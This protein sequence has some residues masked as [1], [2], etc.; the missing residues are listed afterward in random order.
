MTTPLSPILER[1]IAEQGSLSLH[2]F[3]QIALT[4]PEHG[5]YKNRTA[6]GGEGDFIT[7]PEISQ[8]FGELCGLWGFDQMINQ[9]INQH[10]GWVEL[11]PGRGTLMADIIRVASMAGPE[12][13]RKWPV[14]LVEIH[15]EF[16]VEQRAKLNAHTDLHHHQDLSSLPPIPLIFIAN[17][18]F[19][20]LPIR[21]FVS[22]NANWYERNVITD[23]NGLMLSTSS[24][25]ETQLAL[26]TPNEDGIIAEYA[27]DLHPLV[28]QMATHIN[29]YGGAALIIDYGKSNA[30]GDSLQAVNNHQPVDIFHDP[31]QTDLSAWVNFK[32]IRDAAL[33]Q[34][35]KVFGPRSQGDFLRQLGLYQRAE[36]LAL[37]ASK[38]ERRNIAAAVDRLSAPAQ[39][40]NVFK[41]MALLPAAHPITSPEQLAG[42]APPTKMA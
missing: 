2:E 39:M 36:Q 28:G 8:M 11:G 22:K 23:G 5:Y 14:H 16:V 13:N 25:P 42:F 24:T 18:F 3:M 31:G 40:G 26:P 34:G 21:Q 41:V 38:E 15:P 9:Q 10:A 4:H 7:A 37:S 32:A 35:A 29:T 19:D 27:T 30:V 17:E 33:D 20:A 12:N 1:M 6:I